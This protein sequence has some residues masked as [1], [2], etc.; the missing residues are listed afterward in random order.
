MVSLRLL[1]WRS[2]A[3]R[4]QRGEA[5]H[6]REQIGE[7]DTS[8]SALARATVPVR[9]E[10][11]EFIETFCTNCDRLVTWDSSSKDVLAACPTIVP[12]S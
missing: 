5:G 8:S 12:N 10:R 1:A 6:I 11:V 3:P 4:E 9:N 2:S 7:L